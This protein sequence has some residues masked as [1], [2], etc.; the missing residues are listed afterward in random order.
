M[1]VKPTRGAGEEGRRRALMAFR[2]PLR[3]GLQG[4][5][6]G[7]GQLPASEGVLSY[8]SHVEYVLTEGPGYETAHMCLGLAYGRH[9][10][11]VHQRIKL[12]LS[13]TL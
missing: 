10:R 11:Q 2:P 13:A 1:F 7:I 12:I 4:E 6:E 9:G 8:V 5:S 3:T